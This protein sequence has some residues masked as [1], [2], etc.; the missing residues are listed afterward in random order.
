MRRRNDPGRRRPKG[1]GKNT[2]SSAASGSYVALSTDP[3]TL[4]EFLRG[5]SEKSLR[6]TPGLAEAAQKVGGMGTG[7]FGYENQNETVHAALDILKKE[8]GSLANLIRPSPFAQPFRLWEVYK[9]LLQWLDLSL[10]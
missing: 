7:L 9:Q 5:N 2:L 10:L 8:S 1:G 4:E 3:A 6:E